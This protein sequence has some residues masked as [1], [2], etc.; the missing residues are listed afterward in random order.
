MDFFGIAFNDNDFFLL[1]RLKIL[2]IIIFD[3]ILFYRIMIL[4]ER[5]FFKIMEK[6]IL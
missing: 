1:I 4:F 5:K 3:I 6:Y 2:R